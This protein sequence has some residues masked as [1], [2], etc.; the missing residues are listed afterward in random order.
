MSSGLN[1]ADV[2]S[3]GLRG[4][5][6]EE[7]SRWTRGPSFLM[8]DETQW[9][10]KGITRE[11]PLGDDPEVKKDTGTLMASATRKE[12]TLDKLWDR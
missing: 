10:M 7:C 9:P 5:E 1:P 8:L 12:A 6:L 4:D 2:T 11:G 3:R